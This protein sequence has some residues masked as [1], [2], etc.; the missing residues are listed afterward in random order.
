M[1]KFKVTATYKRKNPK[2]FVL[3]ETSRFLEMWAD[4]V[5][6][7]KYNLDKQIDLD[8]PIGTVLYEYG[9]APQPGGLI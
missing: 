9:A 2:T 4:N 5:E 7:V 8:T 6:V 3:E 1:E